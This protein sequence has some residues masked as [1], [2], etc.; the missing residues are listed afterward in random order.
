[1]IPANG[2]L[3]YQV[4]VAY[5]PQNVDAVACGYFLAQKSLI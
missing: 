5:D 4:D 3:Y 1:V 2:R